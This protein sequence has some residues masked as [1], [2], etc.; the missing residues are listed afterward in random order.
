MFSI[1]DTLWTFHP[2]GN[3][4]STDGLSWIKSTLPNAIHNLAFLD[5]VQFKNAIYG[6]GHFEGNIESFQYS[7]KI[8]QSKDLRS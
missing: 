6:I 5:Y 8:Y 1:Q 4:Y 3:W 2:D 7:P